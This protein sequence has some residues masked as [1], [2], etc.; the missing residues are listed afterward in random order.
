M[1]LVIV[2]FRDPTT[3]NQWAYKDEVDKSK[4]KVCLAFGI[5]VEENEDI[6]KVALLCS[7]D[8]GA[9]S[10]WVNIPTGCVLTCDVIKEVDWE[11]PD[12]KIS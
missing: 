10:N 7:G 2:K 3:F 4:C 8:K 12:D 1:Q 9:F 5:L 11:A 6:T